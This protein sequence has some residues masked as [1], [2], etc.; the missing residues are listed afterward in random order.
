MNGFNVA[1]AVCFGCWV[2]FLLDIPQTED[3]IL[4]TFGLACVSAASCCYFY[5]RL[6]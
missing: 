6:Q 4:F 1:R 2:L 5:R 3:Q